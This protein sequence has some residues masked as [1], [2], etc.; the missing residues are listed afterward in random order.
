MYIIIDEDELF[1][2]FI[3]IYKRVI[4][5]KLIIFKFEYLIWKCFLKFSWGFNGIKRNCYK[6]LLFICLVKY[7]IGFN[8]IILDMVC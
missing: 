7:I 6:W 8:K 3:C 2:L 4:F 1:V 5:L